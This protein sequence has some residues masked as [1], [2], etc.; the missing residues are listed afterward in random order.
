MMNGFTAPR[1]HLS[2]AALVSSPPWHFAGA[3]L[4]T[5]FWNDPDVSVHAL[6]A[7]VELD[8]KCPG[9]SGACGVANVQAIGR[10]VLDLC[11]TQCDIAH[12]YHSSSSTLCKCTEMEGSREPP[13]ARKTKVICLRAVFGRHRHQHQNKPY[14]ACAPELA[15]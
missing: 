2:T 7:G 6:P 11:T 3:V 5:E 1:S 8:K 15:P 13:C 10:F 4:A 14:Y 12:I 9:H